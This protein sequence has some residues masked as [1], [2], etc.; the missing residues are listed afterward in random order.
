MTKKDITLLIACLL[1]ILIMFAMASCGPSH[2]LRKSERA[3]KK[4]IIK[5]AIVNPDTIYKTITVY[6]PKIEIDTVLRHVNFRDT[7]T[8]QKD[9][10]ITRI[11]YDTLTKLLYVNTVCPSDTVFVKVPVSVTNEISC[12]PKDNKWKWIAISLGVVLIAALALRKL[13]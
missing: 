6:T 1:F 3:L 8:V 9:K 12:P 11:K 4:A 2:Y 7:I 13:F 10:V 5:G